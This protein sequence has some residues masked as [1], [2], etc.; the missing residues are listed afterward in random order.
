M[1]EMTRRIVLGHIAGAHGMRGE[2]LV[3]SHTEDAAS[4]GAY[5][6]LMDEKSGR[7]L[8]LKVVRVTPK[9]VVARVAGVSDRN[10]AEA[11]K[12]AV[13]AVDRER[14]PQADE[15][16]YYHADLIG[17]T[18]WDLEGKKIGS[19][20]AVANYG[21]GDLL[22]IALAGSRKTEL[23]P[24]T[25]AFVPKVDVAGGT[26]TIVLPITAE[27]DGEDSEGAPHS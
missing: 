25:R 10:A 23:V 3:K 22:E 6:P 16:E 7:V 17:L 20:V 19:V 4:I 27:D 11:L 18:A 13:L 9:G 26:V 1:N 12:G 14:L 21:A 24:F 5:G 2:V 8:N 15:E